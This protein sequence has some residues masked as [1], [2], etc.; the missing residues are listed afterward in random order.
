MKA[1]EDY[2]KFIELFGKEKA[3]KITLQEYVEFWSK[4]NKEI[5]EQHKS[6]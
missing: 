3:D 6:K 2:K 1:E 5:R 4:T